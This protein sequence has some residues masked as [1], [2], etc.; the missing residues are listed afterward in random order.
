[1]LRRGVLSQDKSQGLVQGLHAKFQLQKGLEPSEDAGSQGDGPGLWLPLSQ[2]HLREWGWL[3][4]EKPPGYCCLLPR[5]VSV[6]LVF[7]DSEGERQ[8]GS[9]APPPTLGG[10]NR[11]HAT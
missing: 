6:G 9:S 8:L 3:P 4:M 5:T 10:E 11:V 2:C 7:P 1:M